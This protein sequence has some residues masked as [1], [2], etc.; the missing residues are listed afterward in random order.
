MNGRGFFLALTP[1]VESPTVKWNNA[2]T[3]I[4]DDT[5]VS[6]FVTQRTNLLNEILAHPTWFSRPPRY[7][8]I[9]P[10]FSPWVSKTMQGETRFFC[11]TPKVPGDEDTSGS[12]AWELQGLIMSSTAITPVWKLT[13][14]KQDVQMDTISLFGD[15]ETVDGSVEEDETGETREIQLDEIEDASPAS[16]PTRIRNREWETRKFMFKERVREARLKAQI[17]RRL[18]H[19]EE[20]RFYEIFGELEDAESHFSEYDLTDDESSDSGSEAEES[21]VIGQ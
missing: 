11:E 19:K 2:G 13:N 5:N 9:E 17:A 14:I 4:S 8:I 7:D 6:W 21:A 10:L 16:G 1:P 18:A 15:G 12:A 20:A 3:W